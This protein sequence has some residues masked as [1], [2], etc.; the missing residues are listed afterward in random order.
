MPAAD[1]P[2]AIGDGPIQAELRG[3][4]NALAD[5]IDSLLNGEAQGADRKTGFVLLVFPFTKPDGTAYE[6]RANYISNAK[7]D[8]IVVLLK[9]QLARFEGQP[10][11]RGNA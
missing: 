6:G 1:K 11:V 9:Q 10:D 4:M 5:E 7:R 3:F 8:D 2:I